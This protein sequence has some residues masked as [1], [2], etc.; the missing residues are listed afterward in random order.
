MCSVWLKTSIS[1]HPFYYFVIVSVVF[2]IDRVVTQHTPKCVENC[3]DSKVPFNCQS[4]V[5]P[6]F[7]NLGCNSENSVFFT[8][9]D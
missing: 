5:Y 4:N 3:S 1:N 6:I 2:N 9:V 7:C 8:T